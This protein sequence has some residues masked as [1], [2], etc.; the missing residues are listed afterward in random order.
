MSEANNHS[1][2]LKLSGE[3]LRQTTPP[4]ILQTGTRGATHDEQRF[5]PDGLVTTRAAYTLSRTARA[6]AP[7]VNE[8]VDAEQV[9]A[10]ELDDGVTVF[11]RVDKLRDDLRELDPT[12][13]DTLELDAIRDR[14]AASRGLIGDVVRRLFVL[15]LGRD[16]LLRRAREQAL[17]WARER[18]GDAASE[19]LED[20]ARLGVTWLG[21]KALM[22]AIESQLAREPGLYRWVG[23]RGDASDL[24]A[25]DPA[26]LNSDVAKGPLLLFIHGTGSST[27]G[28]FGDLLADQRE[29]RE[30]WRRLGARFGDRIFAFEHRTLS[31]S[32]IENA[33]ALARALPD[34]ARFSLVTHSRGG[35]VGDLL[36]LG[37]LGEREIED[38]RRDDPALTD[39]DEEHRALLRELVTTLRTKQLVIERY[40]RVACPA[41]GTRLASANFDVFLGGLLSLIGLVPLLAGQPV[42]AALKRAVLEIA[43][44]RT[45]PARV[46]GIEAMLPGA[47]LGTL[48]MR[49]PARPGIQLAVIAGDIEGGGLLK[50]LGVFFTDLVLFDRLNND[51]VV[52]TDSM[53]AGLARPDAA[54]WR[55]EQ[56]AEVSHFRYFSNEASRAALR[57]WLTEPD[58][59]QIE[60]FRALDGPVPELIPATR[61]TPAALD[62][63]KPVVV[64]LPGIMGSHLAR[65]GGRDRVWLDPDDL[66]VGG[67]HK[68]R[69]R[70]GDDDVRA[71]ALLQRYYG[72]LVEHLAASH[73]CVAG[74]YDWRQ[75]LPTLAD[76]LAEQLESL[77]KQTTQPLRLLA[78]SMGG[79]VVRA[80]IAKHPATWERL[81]TRDGARFIMLGTPNLGSYK[82]VETLIGKSSMVRNLSR[83][84]L[85]HD[86]Q[87]VLDLIG[88][89]P[90]ALQLL[91]RPGTRVAADRD[92]YDPKLWRETLKP[93]L[94]DFWFGDRVCATPSDAALKAGQWLWQQPGADLE[95]LPEAQRERIIYVCGQADVTPYGLSEAGG[96]IKMLG[97]AR[98]DGAVTWESGLIPGIGKTYYAPVKHGDLCATP[99]HFPALME[100]LNDGNTDGLPT[101]PALARD[102][103]RVFTYDAGPTPQPTAAEF[104]DDV[105]DASPPRRVE[106]QAAQVLEVCCTAMDLRYASQPLLVGHYEGDVI[107]GAEAL[108]DR[109]LVGG[110]LSRRQHLGLYAGPLGTATVVLP[111]PNVFERQRGCCRGA[112]VAG[113]GEYGKLNGQTLTQAVQTATLR[114]LL[115]L[116]E[117]ARTDVSEVQL[118][119]LL[120]GYNSTANFTIEG[121]VGAIVQG[122]L[123]ANRR[124]REVMP[125]SLRVARLEFVEL[126]LD[127]AITIAHAI[128]RV[129]R[130]YNNE[131]RDG[132]TVVPVRGLLRCDGVR[133]RLRMEDVPNYWPRL[134]VTNADAETVEPATARP[135]AAL[136]ER[137]RFIYLGQRARAESVFHQR[138]PELI[139]RLVAQS[140]T[141]QNFNPELAR[142]LFQLIVP[143]DFKEAARLFGQILLVLDGYTANLPWE[144]MMADTVPLAIQTAMVRQLSSQ[145][146][147]AQVRVAAGPLAY[148][149]GNPSV[150]GFARHFGDPARALPRDPDPLQGAEDEATAVAD[151]L[152][153]QGYQV[154]EAIGDDQLAQDVINKLYQHPYRILHIAAHGVFE[155]RMANGSLRSGVVLSD[156]LL[157][158]A[159]EI[160]AM[161][162]VPEIA[163]LNCCHLGQVD[164][165][166][167][168]FNRLAYSVAREL[169]EIGVRAVIVA[170]WAVHDLAARLFAETFYARLIQDNRSFG[171]AVFD[172]R[173]ATYELYP[174]SNTWGAYQAYGEPGYRIDPTKPISAAASESER[175]VAVEELLDRIGQQRNEIAR[176]EALL[177]AEEA[178]AIADRI[179][180]LLDDCPREWRGLARTETLL[181]QLYGDLGSVWLERA[182]DHYRNAIRA[183]RSDEVPIKAI[184]QLAN[185]EARLGANLRQPRLIETALKRLL[186]LNQLS[187]AGDDR[188]PNAERC[189]LLGSAYKRLAS[190]HARQVLEH[191]D[192]AALKPFEDAV[193]HS[194]FWYQQGDGADDPARFDPNCALN[195]LSLQT[196]LDVSDA[197]RGELI[198]LA[199]QAAAAAQ[200]AYRGNKNYWNAVMPVDALTIEYLLNGSLVASD[201]TAE[202]TATRLRETYD[203]AR[204]D[205]HARPREVDSTAT[206]LCLLA[207]FFRVKAHAAK[208]KTARRGALRAATQ[209]EGLANHLIPRHCAHHAS[210]EPTADDSEPP[211]T[212]AP[213]PRAGRQ[214]SKDG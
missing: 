175:L 111:T 72:K 3:P 210:P 96:R 103:A 131:R 172:A 25:V 162:T 165:G 106:P 67:L 171:E 138:Q 150:E 36:C 21:T 181:G 151:L 66:L 123:D 189:G 114:Y 1:V 24:A 8:A 100:L 142:T 143:H 205:V 201:D 155:A 110:E 11:I 37:E 35:L 79:L 199:Q 46:P 107:S 129:A 179:A 56:G 81:I 94:R 63:L 31:E 44:N 156:G 65:R 15:D 198:E 136:A 204:A 99:D 188:P 26:G 45:H 98:G 207:L 80:L 174:Q 40:V 7:P 209:L 87:D 93:R 14:G 73:N 12:L 39:V 197:M 130:R 91:P 29:A 159:A 70:D 194:A 128:H 19:A 95:T 183:S 214:R 58:A 85:K 47:P 141:R 89:F 153:T 42:Y 30:D 176:R 5:L 195:R 83:L 163:F 55:F 2:E 192:D 69:W 34:G 86:L 161:E 169:I 186:G 117:S 200:S 13:G 170:G 20:A 115:Q 92:L 212:P 76:A 57:R 33:L 154:F 49:A 28:S 190:V 208:N 9:L 121:S 157:L 27:V 193:A 145:R 90:G 60:G 38:F 135:G 118:C 152:R 149:V 125:Q 17:A 109:E 139:E 50:R 41:R 22:W 84:D 74:A 146:F 124:F 196:V 178:Q 167:I 158:T 185:L 116:V 4:R 23:A 144:L 6:T 168:A 62:P 53:F 119:A 82:M 113:L 88:E 61:A 134:I 16:E 101:A 18:L 166:P 133:E 140:V 137:L 105:L 203:H 108:V 132:G 104:I 184:E 120:L 32:P 112:V 126:Y 177:S 51:L 127:T 97:T 147:R 75:S 122:V 206:Q 78:H 191:A 202:A 64:L 71:Q 160:D 10:L 102:T 211:A 54:R 173:R 68:L 52:D 43:R 182:C 48:L 164:R 180:R 187:E 59:T 148:V 77:L 213:K